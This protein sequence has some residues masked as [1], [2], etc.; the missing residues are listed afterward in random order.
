M[1][2]TRII[3]NTRGATDFLTARGMYVPTVDSLPNFGWTVHKAE[4]R[5]PCGA[6][7]IF[8]STDGEDVE[9]MADGGWT[10]PS[11]KRVFDAVF[12][13]FRHDRLTARC[14]ASNARN[15][16]VLQKMGFKIEG[17][18]RCQDGGIVLFG[19]LK[20]ECRLLRKD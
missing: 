7:M 15:V 3:E 5:S 11:A 12:N 20:S 4:S 6:V 8:P 18:K 17:I 2:V 19:M 1:I 16:R 14:M 13:R 9:M 10:V